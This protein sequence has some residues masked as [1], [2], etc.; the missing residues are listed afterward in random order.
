MKPGWDLIPFMLMIGDKPHINMPRIIEAVV[1]AVIVGA[2]AGY[3]SLGKLEVKFDGF[4]ESMGMRIDRIE[5]KVDS[6]VDDLYRPMNE[7]P[8]K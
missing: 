4:K 2:F 3:I 1:I 7:R 6:L 8:R 5:R